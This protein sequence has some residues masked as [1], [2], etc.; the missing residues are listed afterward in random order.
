MAVDRKFYVHAYMHA[1]PPPPPFFFFT[2]LYF[3][4]ASCERFHDVRAEIPIVVKLACALC[5]Q[6]DKICWAWHGCMDGW[7]NEWEGFPH[8]PFFRTN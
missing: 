3:T 6:T 2:L 4:F 1:Y 5:G 7:M 8:V